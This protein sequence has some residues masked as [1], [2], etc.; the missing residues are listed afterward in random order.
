MERNAVCEPPPH[1]LEHAPKAPYLEC[2]QS[3]GHGPALHTA[4]STMGGQVAPPPLAT[5]TMAR[6]RSW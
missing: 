6:L 2:T 1:F 4:P 5:C 3:I